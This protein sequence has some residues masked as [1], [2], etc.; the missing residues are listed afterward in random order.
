MKHAQ[1]SM[2]E[3]EIQNTDNEFRMMIRDNGK[4]F[5]TGIERKGNGLH[6]MKMR[7]R[8]IDAK[9]EITGSAGTCILLRRKRL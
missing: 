6:N 9:L 5:N 1:A 7:A 8:R 4:G 3:I 2:V